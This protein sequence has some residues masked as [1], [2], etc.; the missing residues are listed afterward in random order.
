MQL[1]PIMR[2]ADQPDLLVSGLLDVGDEIAGRNTLVDSPVGKGHVVLFSF[3]PMYR[4]ETEGS[5]PLVFN[6]VMNFDHLSA[7]R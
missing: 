5:Y 6:A 2:F 7:G 1:R 3:N 4:G